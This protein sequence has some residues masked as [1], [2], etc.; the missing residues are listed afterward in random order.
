MRPASILPLAVALMLAG[1]GSQD[2]VTAN[3]VSPEEVATKLAAG[4]NQPTPGRWRWTSKIEKMDISGLLPEESDAIGKP[5]TWFTCVTPEQANLANVEAFQKGARGCTY[6]H[7][8]MHR[9][10]LD[11][12]LTCAAGARRYNAA[13]TGSYSPEDYQISTTAPFELRPGI[14]GNVTTSLEGMKVGECDGT[15]A[16]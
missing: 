8:S 7:F 2:G 9:G 3:N 16:K 15:E 4:H 5:T 12:G 10:V 6:D 13:M 11:A 14:A 1:C